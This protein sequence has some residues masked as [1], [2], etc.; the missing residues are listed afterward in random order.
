MSE[1]D[2]PTLVRVPRP[3]NEQAWEDLR[4][5][6]GLPESH[7]PLQAR[8]PRYT[9]EQLAQRFHEL[10]EELAPRYGYETREESRK[11]WADVPP[12]N[13]ALME[14]VCA[15]M[16]KELQLD[17]AA[18]DAL[19]AQLDEAQ[20]LA[21]SRLRIANS[22]ETDVT[23]A[24]AERDA[25]ANTLRQANLRIDALEAERDVLAQELQQLKLTKGGE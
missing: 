1:T 12:Q 9:N 19:A 16:L 15:R 2:R 3:Q 8:V 17:Q 23:A 7:Q 24:W 25:L 10:Y 21:A 6:G 20:T 11:P 4:A 22:L 13:K 5:D 18:Y 14:M